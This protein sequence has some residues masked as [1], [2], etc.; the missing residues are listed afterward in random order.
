MT[1]EIKK[2]TKVTL[3]L[4][5]CDRCTLVQLP[6]TYKLDEDYY[7]DY[8][9]SRTYS[10]FSKKYQSWLA[11]EF[12]EK[13]SLQNKKVVDVGC[14]DGYFAAFLK[15]HGAVVT[16]IEPSKTAARMARER[17]VQ[18]I[19]KYVDD[20][21]SVKQKFSGFTTC[22]VFEHIRE[23]GKLLTNIKKFME[24]ESYGLIEV[25]SLVKSV[26]D[27]R[28][29][30]FFP[31]HVAYYS[32]TSLSYMLDINGFEVVDI[33]HTANEEY[34][35][36][37]FRLGSR[38]SL[39]LQKGFAGYKTQFEVFLKKLKKKKVAVWGAGGK[40]PALLSFSGIEAADIAYCVDSDPN[41]QG[42]YLLGEIP[43]RHP[44]ALA[45]GGVDIVLVTAMMYN[46]EIIKILK[47]KYSFQDDQIA[48]ISPYPR[49]LNK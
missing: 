40:G 13:F 42:K 25:P 28:F 44:D 24:N 16:G 34:I 35:S 11:H 23:P 22:Q 8:L 9:M 15:D 46:E 19:E 17:G 3:K 26:H 10:A 38:E 20:G 4:Y 21:L 43:V 30:D 37:F 39:D 41:K 7:D 47:N 1:Q 31:D 14:G 32:P 49:F 48:V 45:E 6:D 33:V 27:R 18:V 36:A 2:R 5:K 29:Y 12:V